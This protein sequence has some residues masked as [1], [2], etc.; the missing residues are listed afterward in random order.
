M[1]LADKLKTKEE[2]PTNLANKLNEKS[3]EVAA[4]YNEVENE[5]F[6]YFAEIFRSGKFEALLEKELSKK[7]NLV[8]RKYTIILEFWDYSSGCSDTHFSIW[9]YQWKNTEATSYESQM[10]KGIRLH[11]IQRSCGSRLLEL[12]KSEL[13]K[14]GFK[15]SVEDDESWLNYYRKKI[16]ILW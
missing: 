15:V 13:L 5:I 14:M 3:L 7:H 8:D 12:T 11:D 6:A 16:T 2:H 10:Y 4:T 9:A 1:N